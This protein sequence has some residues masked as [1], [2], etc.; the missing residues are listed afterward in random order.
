[1]GLPPFRSPFLVAVTLTWIASPLACGSSSGSDLL[2]ASGSGGA[3][4]A[5]SGTEASAGTGG[6]AGSDQ[7]DA[8][9]DVSE[10]PGDQ[11]DAQPD[12]SPEASALP[13][14]AQDGPFAHEASD[15]KAGSISVHCVVPTAGPSAPPYPIVLI[16][17][18][19]QLES[20]RYY[21]YA[22]R[23]SSF[24]YVACTVDYSNL[25]GQDKDPVAI[26]QVLDW[27]IAESAKPSGPLAGQTDA[28]LVGV[29]GHS[30]GGKAAVMAA[31]LD[32]RFKAVLGLD[33]VNSCPG[34]G[35]CPDGIKA[36][37]SMSIP[38][39]FLGET[40]DDGSGG[41]LQPCAPAADNYQKFYASAQ[42]PSLQVTVNGANHMSF[43]SDLSNCLA[44]GFCKTASADHQAVLDLAYS[45]TVAFFERRLRAI[46]Q[47]DDYL[48]GAKA[49]ERYVDTGLAVLESK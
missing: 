9:S 46:V 14:P 18:G 33:P 4:G 41:G 11:P 36:M 40:V 10:E 12:S 25:S 29:M 16:A 8:Q 37:E 23:L 43:V 38:S 48:T 44:C 17:H 19:F 1:M 49:Q 30:R 34:I 22:D 47:Y 42:P 6:Q 24:G 27:V 21:P 35:T 28:N 3:G 39:A 32:A 26:I 31:S 13:D 45:Y 7:P 20:S 15:G 5:D 2:A